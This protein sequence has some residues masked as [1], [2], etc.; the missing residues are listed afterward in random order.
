MGMLFWTEAYRQVVECS[1][2]RPLQSLPLTTSPDQ[3]L[4]LHLAE[5]G[6]EVNSEMSFCHLMEQATL[7]G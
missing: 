1:F 4:L 7:Q 5:L 2:L 3:L 6:L